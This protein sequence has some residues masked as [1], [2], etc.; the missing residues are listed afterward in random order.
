MTLRAR[1]KLYAS[2]VAVAAACW[3][4]FSLD[5]PS[6]AGDILRV[7]GEA[8]ARLAG[9]CR[10]H[11]VEHAGT[12]QCGPTC[13][14]LA[15]HIN[16]RCFAGAMP[17][18][19]EAAGDRIQ[20]VIGAAYRGDRDRL[21]VTDHVWIEVHLGQEL[22]FIDPTHGQFGPPDLVAQVLDRRDPDGYRRLLGELGYSDISA[23]ARTPELKLEV[24][25]A[26][27]CVEL[28]WIPRDW[29]EWERML[30]FSGGGK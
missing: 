19:T 15:R 17:I 3:V 20:L 9:F 13:W 27:A 18:T 22:V 6:R 26:C 28:G 21:T 4:G 12:W 29:R 11:A 24:R 14:A 23:L 16:A 10:A 7:A 30:L 8:E 25:A 1:L 2:L 5:Q